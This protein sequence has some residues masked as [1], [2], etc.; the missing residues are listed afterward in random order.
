MVEVYERGG[1]GGDR[2]ARV[3]GL[4][5]WGGDLAVWGHLVSNGVLISTDEVNSES[6]LTNHVSL[7][8]DEMSC[9]A[10]R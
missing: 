6:F 3:A 10:R 9:D 5:W 1:M 4:L 7:S 2:E 8:S